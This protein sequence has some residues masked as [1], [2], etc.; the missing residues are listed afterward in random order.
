MYRCYMK[1]AEYAASPNKS[2]MHQNAFKTQIGEKSQADS[3]VAGQ[4]IKD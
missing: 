1:D 2:M 4:V 3:A